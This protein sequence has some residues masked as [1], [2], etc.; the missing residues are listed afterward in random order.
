MGG[1]AGRSGYGPCLAVGPWRQQACPP[2]TLGCFLS[3]QEILSD[4][5]KHYSAVLALKSLELSSAA[6]KEGK[7]GDA[8]G[9]KK[10]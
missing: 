4:T 5:V 3:L 6:S 8:A 10:D 9:D 2:I 7:G 1:R